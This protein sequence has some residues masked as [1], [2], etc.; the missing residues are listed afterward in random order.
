MS[1]LHTPLG[2]TMNVTNFV[3]C[4]LFLLL[5]PNSAAKETVWPIEAA[6]SQKASKYFFIYLLDVGEFYVARS[7]AL[8]A[9]SG[10]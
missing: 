3:L 4:L 7:I 5:Q 1:R 10:S 2:W 9:P 6:C 8:T